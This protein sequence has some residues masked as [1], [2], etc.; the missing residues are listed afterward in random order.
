[1]NALE[2]VDFIENLPATNAKETESNDVACYPIQKKGFATLEVNTE[3]R[4]LIEN[5]D[6][7]Q[8]IVWDLSFVEEIFYLKEFMVFARSCYGVIVLNTAT[9]EIYEISEGGDFISF[10]AKDEASFL[11]TL[12]EIIK[13]EITLS[14]SSDGDVVSLKNEALVKCVSLAGSSE[15]EGFYRSLLC[16]EN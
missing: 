7:S 5:Y 11:D 12:G 9:Q 10:V 15:Y 4:K 14:A 13:L 2:F 8:L 6:V 3:F 16:I 1:M